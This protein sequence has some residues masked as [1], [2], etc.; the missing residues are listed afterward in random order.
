M[1][2]SD[3]DNN[4]YTLPKPTEWWRDNYDYKKFDFDMNIDATEKYE[5]VFQIL[6]EN[7]KLKD[8]DIIYYINN[9]FA[10]MGFYWYSE[11]LKN[12]WT[13]LNKY[14]RERFSLS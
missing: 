9:E 4:W 6:F 5:R 14:W 7:K 2:K 13:F 11:I 1:E 12:C 8:F 10:I 3:Y